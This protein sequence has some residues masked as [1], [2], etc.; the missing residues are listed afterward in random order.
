M[1]FDPTSNNYMGEKMKIFHISSKSFPG[2]KQQPLLSEMLIKIKSCLYFPLYFKIMLKQVRK[3][4]KI[5][6]KI[7]K[8]DKY[9]PH[10]RGAGG[11]HLQ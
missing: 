5:I 8:L 2:P 4:A 1:G 10:R 9:F 6:E 3:K 7:L 11:H